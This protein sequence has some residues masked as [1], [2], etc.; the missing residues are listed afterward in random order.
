[1]LKIG[2]TAPQFT[3]TL[4]NGETFNLGEWRGRKHV[5]LYFYPKD[6]SPGCTREA[7]GFRDNYEPITALDAIVVGVSADSADSHQM[8]REKH[9]LPFPLIPDTDKQ[10]SKLYDARGLLGLT[11]ARITYVIDRQGII[12]G[13]FRHEVR[14]IGDHIADAVRTLQEIARGDAPPQAS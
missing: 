5:V 4:D 7:C 3:A 10:V 2:T 6:D 8:F 12:R 13:A 9:A 1:M 11:T 14:G